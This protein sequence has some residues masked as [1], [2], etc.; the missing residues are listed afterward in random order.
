M[1]SENA[2]TKWNVLMCFGAALAV[3][4]FL[5]VTYR[6]YTARWWF[7]D[8]RPDYGEPPTISRAIVEVEIRVPFAFWITLS[9]IA[10]V[11]SVSTLLYYYRS[12]AVKVNV[13][14]V[15]TRLC[16]RIGLPL[17]LAL[18]IVSA[19]GMYTLSANS[20][21]YQGDM[22][23]LGSYAFFASQ[24]G[25]IL[26]YAIWNSLLLR[27]PAMRNSPIA[28]RL[29]NRGWIKLRLF[30]C[31]IAVAMTVIY[32]GLFLAKEGKSFAEAPTL[33]WA[34][35]GMEVSVITVFLVVVVMAFA[36]KLRRPVDI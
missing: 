34:Y 31:V 33:I 4:S 8:I 19:W 24:A 21:F 29:I 2:K 3:F 16:L 32:L 35:T 25:V 14:S 1:R 7:I 23:M 30:C 12:L 5:V 36:D 27:D 22:H 18:Q 9:G 28:D 15:S 20:L 17:A 11:L 6:I 13:S 26:I 10:L